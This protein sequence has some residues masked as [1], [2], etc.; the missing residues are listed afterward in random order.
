MLVDLSGELLL[1]LGQ[2]STV[3]FTDAVDLKVVCLLRGL[4]LGGLRFDLVALPLGEGEDRGLGGAPGRA[5][6]ERVERETVEG[7]DLGQ[8]A[9]LVEEVC[10]RREHEV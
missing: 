3:V 2:D 9:R 10:G 6:R 7:G 4:D 5:L 8:V 1:Q